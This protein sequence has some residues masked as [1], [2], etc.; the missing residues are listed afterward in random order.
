VPSRSLSIIAAVGA[1]GLL[2]ATTPSG[3]APA[4]PRHHVAVGVSMYRHVLLLSV[5]GMHQSDLRWYTARHPKSALARLA[6]RGTEFTHARSPFPSDSFPGMVGQVTGGNPKTTGIYYDVTYNHYL[7][8]PTASAS[9]VPRKA[10]CAAANPGANIPFD[11]S[12]DRNPDRL[13]AGQGLASLPRDIMKLTKNPQSLIDPHALPIDPVSCTRVYPHQYLKVNTIFEVARKHGLRTAW[14]DKHPA[15]EILNGPSGA[16]VQDL[17]TPEINSLANEQGA[18]WTS[19]NSLTRR[20]DHFKVRAVLNEIAGYDHSRT[21]RVGTPAIF[22]M[23]FQSVSTAQKLPVSGDHLGGYLRHGTTPGPV[24]RGAFNYV[25][26]ELAAMIAALRASGHFRDTAIIVSSKHGQSPRERSALTRIDD[27]TIIAQLN[28]AWATAH[29]HAVQPL[30]AASLDDDAM[31]AWFSDGDRNATAAEF[32]SQYLRRYNG[33]GTGSDG[34]AVAT[35]IGARAKPYT[36][37]GL[38]SVKTGAA[39]AHFLGAV[40]RSARVPDLIGIAQH[41]VVYTDKT[42][43]IAEHGGNDP[44]DRHVPLLVFA[45]GLHHAVRR[46]PVQTTQVA[47][48]VLM[49]LGLQPDALRAV[50]I[51]HTASL[52]IH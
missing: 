23:N 25:N 50:R 22:G 21:N 36:S 48:T 3:G 29:P 30:V 13:D 26:S 12:L 46:A 16:G 38:R 28:A 43:K 17:F 33:N 51:E 7:L 18:D 8:D 20:Y 4:A 9:A 35:D 6:R 34:K 45:P 10:D 24:L 32:A 41:G 14:S 49:L 39:A 5:D 52:R 44:Q 37:S 2:T 19:V 11:E 27:S 47:P 40:P 15:Y 31:L 42:S 1:A